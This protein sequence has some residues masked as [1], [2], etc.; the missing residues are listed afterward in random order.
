[1]L[2]LGARIGDQ[3]EC[4]ALLPRE[5]IARFQPE[6]KNEDAAKEGLTN[7]SRLRQTSA[8]GENPRCP[9]IP[10]IPMKTQNLKLTTT[11]KPVRTQLTVCAAALAG[12]AAG[13]QS[14]NA[15]VVSFTIKRFIIALGI[16]TAGTTIVS[17]EI[18]ET[19]P[20]GYSKAALLG[21]SDTAISVPFIRPPEFIGGIQSASGNTITV[22]QGSWTA[23]QF[24]YAAGTQPNR[25]YAL[26]GAAPTAHPKEGHT[27]TIVANDAN[28]LTVD[29]GVDNLTGI[30]PDAQVS[31]VPNWTLATLFPAEDQ[32]V[33]F[34]PTASTV[35]YKT[36]IRVPDTTASGINIPYT[37][38]YFSNN[39]WRL[40]GDENTDR[41]D[42][43]L[44]PDSYFIVRNLNGA[45]TLAMVSLGAV[46]MKKLTV[47]LTTSTATQ[48][49]NP[50]SLLRPLDVALNA[51]GLNNSDGSF[52]GGDELHLFNNTAVGYDKPTRV[53]VQSPSVLNGRW[54]L[55]GDPNND[56]G[57]EIIP[58]A[59]GFLVRKAPAGNGLP[60]FWSNNFPVHAIKAV[61]RKT[62]GTAGTFDIDLPLSG[63]PG[64]ECRHAAGNHKVVFT[65]PAPVTVSGAA[66]TSGTATTAAP[67]LSTGGTEVT[68][69]LSGV[70]NA[71]RITVTL[72]GVTDGAN[73]NDVAVR[74]GLLPGD[75]TGSGSVN[76]SDISQTKAQSGQP[77]SA[78]NFRQ[79][80]TANGSINASDI[81]LVK[82]NSGTFLPPSLTMLAEQTPEPE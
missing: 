53:Y 16:V 54:T 5:P 77:V 7:E 25:Y 58:A 66:V 73:S 78:S 36:Q 81:G 10:T 46:H 67:I 20:V 23:N 31:V 42:E 40:V 17:A 14:A 76:S 35:A 11:S 72:L 55:A 75:T 24:V 32:N 2:R 50:V 4:A 71:Q 64:I 68:V 37:T 57:A 38:Y 29:L 33:S 34:T 26:V 27:Y 63:T 69:D 3:T 44:L 39:A 30:P 21:E 51:T 28:T 18:V 45:P 49:D 9:P 47:P 59:N 12:T 74:M 8:A 52:V 82:S 61:S 80:V 13:I 43:P 70:T 15:A 62:H 65:F 1:L 41:G 6:N 56:R 48:Q 79:D 60:A 19:D 22:R